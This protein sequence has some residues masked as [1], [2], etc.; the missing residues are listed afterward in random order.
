MCDLLV[1]DAGCAAVV[2]DQPLRI[3]REGRQEGTALDTCQFV[4]PHLVEMVQGVGELGRAHQHDTSALGSGAEHG[5]AADV[6]HLDHRVEGCALL[7]DF[8]L[9][10]IQVDVDQVDRVDLEPFEFLDLL[11]VGEVG[12]NRRVDFAR[13]GDNLVSEDGR[14]DH[15]R[16]IRHLNLLDLSEEQRRATGGHDIPSLEVEGLGEF[17][18]LRG[19]R[20]RREQ[21]SPGCCVR[22]VQK[23]LL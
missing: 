14:P 8:L 1:E 10:G 22:K 2:H 3:G 15:G 11:R 16:D 20:V 5:G 9:E 6:G 17:L 18:Q 4:V 19:F 7:A 21:G 13:Q 12:E 23:G